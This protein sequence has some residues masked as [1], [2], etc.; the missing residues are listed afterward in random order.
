MVD[1]TQPD[2]R[3]TVAEHE[4]GDEHDHPLPKGTLLM[5]LGYLVLI[6]ALWVQIYFMLLSSGGIPRL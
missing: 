1:K 3:K 6:T 5:I 2:E 4:G